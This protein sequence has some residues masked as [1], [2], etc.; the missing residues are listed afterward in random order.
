MH[1]PIG[2]VGQWLRKSAQRSLSI[3]RCAL[4]RLRAHWIGF[5]PLPDSDT[6]GTARLNRRSQVGV[7]NEAAAEPHRSRTGFRPANLSSLSPTASGRDDP[8]Q[9]ARCGKPARRDS[10]QGRRTTAVPTATNIVNERVCSPLNES[11]APRFPP[12]RSRLSSPCEFAR[13]NPPA[14]RTPAAAG[15]AAGGLSGEAGGQDGCLSVPQGQGSVVGLKYPC[16][17]SHLT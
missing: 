11:P 1:D 4:Q 17:P 6:S 3:L 16:M 12:L 7:V 8:R 2:E 10:V 5:R 14:T 15:Q 9:R 13:P